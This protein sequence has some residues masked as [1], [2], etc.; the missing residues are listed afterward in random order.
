MGPHLALC[1]LYPLA[2]PGARGVRMGICISAGHDHGE[3]HVME[4]PDA[5]TILIRWLIENQGIA[6]KLKLAN[7]GYLRKPDQLNTQ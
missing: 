3:I 6:S 4:L 2:I 1:Q 7:T 5:G